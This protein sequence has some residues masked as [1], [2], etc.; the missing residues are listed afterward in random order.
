MKSGKTLIELATEI[1]RRAEAK[2]DLVTSSARLA[3]VET[4]AGCGNAGV[5]LAITGEDSYAINDIAHG[6][7]GEFAGIPAKYYER[8][9]TEAPALL[10]KNVNHWLSGNP[11]PRLI[12]TMDGTV[13]AMLSDRYRPLENEDL[14]EAV[15]PVIQDLGLDIMSC[16]VTERRLYIKVV[17]PRVTRELKAAGGAWGD[18]NH[19]IIKLRTAMPAV[20]ISNSEV[21]MG[22]LS[23]L[24]GLYDG[25]C[26]NLASFGERS[27]RKYHAGAKHELVGEELYA[28]LS[29]ETRRVSDQALWMQ[30]RDT[31]KIAFDRARFDQLVD[32]VEGTIHDKVEDPVQVVS[33]ASKK[34]GVTE[35]H[36]KSILRHLVEGGSLSRFGLYNAITRAS[37][38]I[39]S[40]D[41]ATRLEA[42]GGKIIE[43]P[44]SEWNVLA[45]AA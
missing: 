44:K 37:Q 13:R 7:I 33:L 29:P 27:A 40:Y 28:L 38:D 9:K 41:E 18:G 3:M 43:L 14:A 17:D 6:Q 30:I 36:G 39:E 42:I 12:R 5:R 22:A 35:E 1:Q 31:V 20:T 32:K 2:K 25:F 34:F 45:K 19:N 23:V 11:T 24:G 21:G 15:L 8:M 4:N 26:S 16:D 10:A